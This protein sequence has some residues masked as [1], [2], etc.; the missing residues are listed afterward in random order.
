MNIGDGHSDL[1][2]HFACFA[3]GNRIT[4]H[5]M[6]IFANNLRHIRLS[7]LCALESAHQARGI[8]ASA[9][10]FLDLGIIVVNNAG[11]R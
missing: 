8:P 1:F 4:E 11:D 7:A 2:Q 3:I 5:Y 10:H 6:F 9:A